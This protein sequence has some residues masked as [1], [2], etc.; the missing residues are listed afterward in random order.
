MASLPYPL[1]HDYPADLVG[2]ARMPYPPTVSLKYWILRS[3]LPPLDSSLFTIRFF[4]LRSSL[5]PLDSSLFT[6]PSSF[7]IQKIFKSFVLSSFCSNFAYMKRNICKIMM[8]L[9]GLIY[10]TP[11]FAQNYNVQCEDTC[12]HVH[13][14]DLSHY[15]GEVFGRL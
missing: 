15:Q 7:A 14:I 12:S 1:C 5:P 6:S 11:S 13:G 8:A 2:M 3:S 4:T 9:L 10:F